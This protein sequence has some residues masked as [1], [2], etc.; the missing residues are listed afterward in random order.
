MCSQA[1]GS[2]ESFKQQITNNDGIIS[3][4][5]VSGTENLTIG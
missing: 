5:V 4:R 2:I 3:A 1:L